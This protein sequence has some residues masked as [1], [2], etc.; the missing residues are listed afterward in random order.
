[1]SFWSR[2][3]SWFTFWKAKEEPKLLSLVWLLSEPREL[4]DQELARHVLS[5][6][7][8][9]LTDTDGEAQE[10]VAGFP[11]ALIIRLRECTFLVNVFPT[12]YVRDK[13]KTAEALGE[14]RRQKALLEHEAWLSVD[15]LGDR[16]SDPNEERA[17]YRRLGRLMAELA[18]ESCLALY[19]PET[20]QLLPFDAELPGRLRGGDVLDALTVNALVDVYQVDGESPEVAAA[21]AEARR[22]WPEFVAAFEQREPD[23]NFAAKAPFTAEGETEFMW[24]IVDAVEGDFILGRMD[25]DPVCKA[26][27]GPGDRVRVNVADLNDWVFFSRGKEEGLFV[28]KVIL[29]QRERKGR[30]D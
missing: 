21:V 1:M 18:D 9:D 23:D 24:F 28:T 16:P 26:L 29:R 5:A 7:G 17:I 12:P 8:I 2:L 6:W 22:R 4:D 10:F 13:A 11:P 30:E 15:F 25:S 20:G 14:L 19:V 27:P 3:K